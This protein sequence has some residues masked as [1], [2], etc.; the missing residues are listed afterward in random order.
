MGRMETLD[1]A[2]RLLQY[3]KNHDGKCALGDKSD[4]DEIRRAFQVSK[5][6]YKKAVGDLYKKRLI[7]ITDGGI[8]LV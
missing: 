6:T 5:K 8:E 2:G 3:L 4:A 1:F 7:R